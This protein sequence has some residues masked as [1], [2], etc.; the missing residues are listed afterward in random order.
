MEPAPPPAK[1]S[2]HVQQS[3][4]KD[5]YREEPDTR[6]GGVADRQGQEG[7]VEGAVEGMA[8]RQRG[9]TDRQGGVANRQEGVTDQQG[10]VA[11]RQ[12]NPTSTPG[13]EKHPA[14]SHDS[15]TSHMS[16]HAVSAAAP[17]PQGAAPS[18]YPSQQVGQAS[19]V[20]Y[21]PPQLGFPSS[22][23]GGQGMRGVSEGGLMMTSSATV[24]ATPSPLSSALNLLSHDPDDSVFSPSSVDDE[25]MK[26]IEQ[27]SEW[28]DELV[29]EQV[30]VSVS[31][32]TGQ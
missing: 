25:R 21:P 28:W 18:S 2:G 23:V 30:H 9:V 6:Q 16:T 20:Q 12:A 29:L 3:Q 5:S 22:M 17:L 19:G 11:D 4:S 31:T 14:S 1:D 27:V 8:D 15:S 10:G 32:G 13:A 24:A 26:I 7:A